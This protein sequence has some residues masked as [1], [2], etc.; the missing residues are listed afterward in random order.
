MNSTVAGQYRL[1]I[2]EEPNHLAYRA[3][4]DGLRAIAV[5]SVVAFHAFP[6]LLPGGFIGVDIFFVISG[7]LISTILLDSLE[8]GSFKFLEFYARRVKRIFPA[9]LVVITASYAF[10]WFALFPDEFAQLG[11][12]IAGG[13]SF[14]SNLVSLNESGYFDNAAHAKPLLHL[15]SLGIEEQFYIFWPLLLWATWQIHVS[16]FL[17]A[18]VLAF[19]SFALNLSDVK[20][21]QATTFYSPLTRFWELL[22]GAVF[23]GYQKQSGATHGEQIGIF[24]Y[25]TS[26]SCGFQDIIQAVS[27]TNKMECQAMT[28]AV[29]I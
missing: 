10:G 14:I 9:L 8:K 15:W 6:S 20:D 26:S 27:R 12:H 21:S 1:E 7:F 23:D 2:E 29:A 19:I 11:K 13:A 4:I 17:L 18:I 25:E 24:Q 3:D 16:P 22:A 28:H 5:L